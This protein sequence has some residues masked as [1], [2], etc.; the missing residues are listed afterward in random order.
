MIFCTYDDKLAINGINAWLQY[1]LPALQ[2][3]GID[4][5]VIY[6]SWAAEDECTTI[7]VLK[8]SGINCYRITGKK[9]IEREIEWILNHVKNARPDIFVASNIVPALYA[10]KWIQAAGIPTIGVI[11]NDD[12]EYKQ[13]VDVFI[14]GSNKYLNAAVAVS[15]RLFAKLP[16]DPEKILTRKIPYGTPLPGFKAIFNKDKLFRIVYTGRLANVQKNIDTVV[17]ALCEAVTQL[18]DVEAYIYGSGP[19]SDEVDRI[20]NEYDHPERI[21]VTGIVPNAFIREKLPEAHVITLM[22][23]YEGLPVALMEAMA[24]GVVPVCKRT[25]SGLPELI[26]ENVTGLYINDTADFVKKIEYLK[27]NPDVW[28]QLSMNAKKH[29]EENYSS[30]KVIAEWILLFNELKPAA[31]A[32]IKIPAKIKLPKNNILYALGENREPGIFTKAARKLKRTFYNA[33]GN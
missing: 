11:H 27:R 9:Y 3:Q 4:V 6:H 19:D 14:N 31:T 2:L 8:K 22:S 24:F 32:E 28:E 29:I 1:L 23:D 33:S 15:D 26:I 20:I 5:S 17:R 16:Q 7:P 12:D 10:A 18:P 30:K 13:L 21:H 25:E